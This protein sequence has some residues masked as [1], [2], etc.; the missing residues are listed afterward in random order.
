[1]I[2]N[3]N[4][5]M[6]GAKTGT[7]RERWFRG[8]ARSL[9][10][11]VLLA[12]FVFIIATCDSD[13]TAF[14]CAGG[15]G[16]DRYEGYTLQWSDEFDGSE[17]DTTVWR[18]DTDQEGNVRGWGNNEKQWYTGSEGDNV[19]LENGN[20]VIE[21]QHE[22][23]GGKAY[24][25]GRVHTHGGKS[26]QFGIIEARIR[27]AT[28]K[29]DNT[30]VDD[31][32]WPAFWLLG[33]SFDGWGHGALYGGNTGWPSSGEIDVME[34][35]S[36]H[37]T[38]PS[39]ALHWAAENPADCRYNQWGGS[40]NPWCSTSQSVIPSSNI[41]TEYHVYGICWDSTSIEWYLDDKVFRRLDISHSQFDE[42]RQPFF[43]LLNLAIDGNSGGTPN[44][45]NYPQKMYVDWVKHWQK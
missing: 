6:G 4:R 5:E 43:I 23:Q 44:S 10:S 13:S 24:T 37:T 32:V 31:G 22:S 38:R 25:S 14:S 1:M 29:S 11:V 20:L 19:Y 15:S 18:Y 42:I 27:Q 7:G 12:I 33:D 36:Q 28:K 40:N 2:L 3:K 17:L 8:S 45:A 9:T 21:A 34:I 16:N 39:G 26:F 41:H 30:T 35:L